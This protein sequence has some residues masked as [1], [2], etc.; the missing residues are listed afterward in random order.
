M[1][2]E[3]KPTESPVEMQPVTTEETCAAA[4]D[5]DKAEATV[6]TDYSGKGLKDLI[7]A[8][9]ALL[10][11]D[12]MQKLHKDAEI[13]KAAFYKT[14]RKEKIASGFISPDLADAP[15][16]PETVQEES[17]SNPFVE[18]EKVFKELYSSYREK[19]AA[20][21]AELEKKKQENLSLKEK[22]ISDLKALLDS[23]DDLKDTFPAFREIQN[24]WRE[25]GPVA[26]DK[27]KDIYDTYQHYVEMFYDYVKIN[28]EF[29]DLDFKKNLEAKVALCEKVEAL[30]GEENV[31]E[32]FRTLQKCHE[33]W[34]EL[35]PVSKEY[36]E[37]IWDRFREATTVINKKHQ[38]YYETIKSEQEENL[39]KKTAL[40]ERVEAILTAEVSDS[41]TWNSL[42]KQIEDIQKEWRSIG[43]ATK[44]DNQKI[45]DRFRKACDDFFKKK[46]EFYSAFKDK[47]QD[48]LDK[49]TAICE[50]AE[51]L[52][53]SEEWKE[54]SDKLIE[55]QKQ[56]KEI[57]PVSRKN[58]E[59]IW[60]R[61]R[62]ACDAFFSNREKKSG[63]G[64]LAANLEAKTS[65][66]E[67][68]KAFDID[69]AAENAFAELKEFQKKWNDIGFVPIREKD[70]IQS[71]FKAAMDE[72]FNMLRGGVSKLKSSNRKGSSGKAL[73]ERDKLV[74]L[75]KKK[76]QEIITLQNNVGFFAKSKN[77][78]S[79]INEINR[80]IDAAREELESLKSKISEIDS[81]SDE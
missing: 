54:T 68:V 80:Q 52:S 18:I 47:M 71:E 41:G 10:A 75:F 69:A 35:G 27:V 40:C 9:Q 38:A 13:L 19:R 56:W 28:M 73:S 64:A 31:V 72:K 50:A 29:R 76:E 8:F 49:K 63:K 15:E 16:S 34:K 62:A 20:F 77:A 70:R 2:E 67:A 21:T 7:D 48:N 42:S 4:V 36:R 39:V 65:L 66:I 60:K 53:S 57:G 61:F 32:A 44:K 17:G 22:V 74:Q 24:R 81:K 23:R 59:E 79:F 12:D 6:Q 43:F 25:I 78:E 3:L 1:S 51:A 37:E 30:A 55:L 11:G 5:S 45:Y 33:E 26:Q 58:S 14:L 46:R